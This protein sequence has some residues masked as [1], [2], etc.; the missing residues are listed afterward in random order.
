MALY[1]ARSTLPRISSSFIQTATVEWSPS[2]PGY[3]LSRL[4]LLWGSLR[5]FGTWYEPALL[6]SALGQSHGRWYFAYQRSSPGAVDQ[7]D[8][9]PAPF[10]QM[11]LGLYVPS[12][13]ALVAP[14]S[15]S[16]CRWFLTHWHYPQ[17]SRR[18]YLRQWR[19]NRAPPD[20]PVAPIAFFCRVDLRS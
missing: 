6:R 11:I 13:I 10:W 15:R 19:S 3:S 5:S 7:A 9:I 8:A 2:T 16:C 12:A 14:A 4:A 18:R 20:R 17:R 1:D